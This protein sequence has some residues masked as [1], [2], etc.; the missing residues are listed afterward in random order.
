MV[1]VDVLLLVYDFLLPCLVLFDDGVMLDGWCD[2]L[3]NCGVF[4]AC[5]APVSSC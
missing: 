5:L 3:L 1:V 4:L 2:F